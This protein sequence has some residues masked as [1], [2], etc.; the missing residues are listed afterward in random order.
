MFYLSRFFY[1]IVIISLNSCATPYQAVG[2]RSGYSESRIDSN[3][4]KVN[5]SGNAFT[6]K[7]AV[8]NNMLYR[9]AEVTLQYNY[10]YFVIV[11]GNTTPTF[12]SYTTPG[13]YNQ[14]TDF[15]T[16][17]TY[18]SYQPGETIN[19]NKFETSAT[20]KMFKGV[21]PVDFSNS[22]NAHEVVKYMKPK[23]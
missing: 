19:T 6:S 15:V 20:I 16:N 12:N 14:Y 4:V 1:L 7:T 21:K 11:S 18:S 9:C 8:E 3:T 13:T 17:S 10:D 22:Y 23:V 5:F 2:F